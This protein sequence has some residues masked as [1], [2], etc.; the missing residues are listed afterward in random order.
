MVGQGV[1]RK[2]LLNP[3]F[4]VVKTIRQKPTGKQNPKL[5]EIVQPD[6]LHYSNIE[7]EL[8]GFDA[9]FFCLGVSS[10]GM[11]DQQYKN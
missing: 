5:R 6:L 9:C 2:C 7:S 11:P 10:A 1:L 4:E 8:K 3:E